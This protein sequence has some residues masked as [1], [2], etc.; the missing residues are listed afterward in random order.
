MGLRCRV[1]R[2]LFFCSEE[3]IFWQ[4]EAGWFFLGGLPRAGW[5]M[6]GGF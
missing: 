1:R 6:I 5:L 4:A 3:D 2:G